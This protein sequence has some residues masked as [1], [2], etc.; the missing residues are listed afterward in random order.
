MSRSVRK[1]HTRRGRYTYL[2]YVRWADDIVILIDAYPRHDWLLRAVEKRLREE[3][4]KLHVDINEERSRVVDLA[5]EESFGF[6]GFDFRR[7]RSLRGVWRAQYTPQLR[8]RTALRSRRRELET[9]SRLGLHGH[10][11][12]N[13]GY[14]QGHD[15]ADHRASS[16]LVRRALVSPAPDT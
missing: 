15:L 4:T 2:E 11:R 16:R 6:L 14:R 8:R 7:V 13:P 12:G 10:E 3:L 5:K 1:W 9:E